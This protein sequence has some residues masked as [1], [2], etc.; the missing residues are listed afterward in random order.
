MRISDQAQAAARAQRALTALESHPA[1]NR[2]QL[3]A[4]RELLNTT[5]NHHN[6]A[7][8]RGALTA[9]EDLAAAVGGRPS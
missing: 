4:A 5:R 7:T 9:L 6:P 1:T 8:V 2:T 3:G